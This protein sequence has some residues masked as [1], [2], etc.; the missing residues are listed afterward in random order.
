MARWRRPPTAYA[1]FS[2]G[3]GASRHPLADGLPPGGPRLP[4]LLRRPSN[5]NTSTSAMR[6]LSSFLSIVPGAAAGSNRGSGSGAAAAAAVAAVAAEGR[7]AGKDGG[8]RWVFNLEQKDKYKIS[9]YVR[10]CNFMHYAK[11]QKLQGLQGV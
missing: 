1:S 10:C 9:L 6:R 2:Q 11:V 8:R 5:N 3:S 7:P 4:A